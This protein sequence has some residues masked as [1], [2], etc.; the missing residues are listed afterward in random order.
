MQKIK[1]LF[2]SLI[3]SAQFF[4]CNGQF[5]IINP[6]DI[7]NLKRSTLEI[8]LGNNVSDESEKAT[9]DVFKQFWTFNNFE[10]VSYNNY[11]EHA[12]DSTHF[13]FVAI[14]VQSAYH[15]KSI[16]PDPLDAVWKP[17]TS[18]SSKGSL[19]GG[20]MNLE[21]DSLVNLNCFALIKAGLNKTQPE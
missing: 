8:V 14:R 9:E 16:V 1:I 7:S 5:K 18:N 2:S 3:L 21:K 20:V 15:A 12:L 17:D 4:Y 19:W 11:M 10:F 6:E 13:Y